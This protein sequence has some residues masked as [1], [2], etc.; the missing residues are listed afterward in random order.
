MQFTEPWFYTDRYMSNSISQN[1]EVGA[2]KLCVGG[3]LPKVQQSAS[4]KDLI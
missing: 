1:H 2:R 4:G 3:S